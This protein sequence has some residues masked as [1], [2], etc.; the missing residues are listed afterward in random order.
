MEIFKIAAIGIIGAILSITLRG[1]RPEVALF[2]GLG[3]S[4]VI[5]FLIA[6]KL[7]E[8]I[9]EFERIISNYGINPEYFKLLIKIIGISYI[10]KFASDVCR[11]SGENAIASKIELAGK[12]TTVVFSLPVIEEFLNLVEKALTDF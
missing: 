3:T 6:G 4:V 9:G 12:L 10:T 5:I 7:E 8:I 11:D 2:T 1:Y